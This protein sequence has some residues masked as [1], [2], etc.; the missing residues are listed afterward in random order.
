MYYYIL[1]ISSSSFSS[2]R[3]SIVLCVIQCA[4]LLWC[5]CSA[6]ASMFW[7]PGMFGAPFFA[8]FA[9]ILFAWSLRAC[10]LTLAHLMISWISQTLFMSSLQRASPMMYLK[11]LISLVLSRHLVVVISALLLMVQV[12]IDVTQI[13]L[14]SSSSSSYRIMFCILSNVPVSF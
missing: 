2:Y 14:S 10:L 6:F 8:I 4:V 3:T 12:I 13:F 7:S 9:I 11:V 5:W 1:F